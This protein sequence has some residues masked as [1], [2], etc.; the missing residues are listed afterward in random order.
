VAHSAEDPS[1]KRSR[2][3]WELRSPLTTAREK[4]AINEGPNLIIKTAGRA[5]IAEIAANLP[6]PP[7]PK[8]ETQV[9]ANCNWKT[10]LNAR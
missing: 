2:E 6:R 8:I 10:T 4:T 9:A 7:L 5:A 3:R 1:E